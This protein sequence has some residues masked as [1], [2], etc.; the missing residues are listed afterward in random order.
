MIVWGEEIEV[1]MNIII[2]LWIWAKLQSEE[3]NLDSIRSVLDITHNYAAAERI[4]MMN[5]VPSLL[6]LANYVSFSFS[7]VHM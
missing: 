6:S 4:Q 5:H 7:F 1:N 3:T 2:I